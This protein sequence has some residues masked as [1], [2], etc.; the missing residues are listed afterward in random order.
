V[1]GRRGEQR[2][3]RRS[4]PPSARK[5]CRNFRSTAQLHRRAWAGRA[6]AS[7]TRHQ[8]RIEQFHAPVSGFSGT[9][10]GRGRPVCDHAG[11]EPPG[12]GEAGFRA[13][14]VRGRVRR[15]D[16]QGPAV[17]LH[18]FEQLAPPGV[19]GGAVLTSF[20]FSSRRRSRS[21]SWG[22]C[23]RRCACAARRADRLR[24][25]RAIGSEDSGVFPFAPTPTR[26]CCGWTTGSREQ[27]VSSFRY[28]VSSINDDNPPFRDWW[29][30][31]RGFS[32][33]PSTARRSPRGRTCSPPHVIQRSPPRSSHTGTCSPASTGPSGPALEI[34]ATATS[35]RDRFLPATVR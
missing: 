17:F 24:L 34:T 32:Q 7:L 26:G 9:G 18:G 23:G 35:T 1:D 27:P 12:A 3:R 22:C 6:A 5:P 25:P 13:A 28:N 31:S 21:G 2:R 20:R 29:G 33:G 14:A 8:E 11:A 10:P 16:Q 19:G 30:Y 4:P 15:T